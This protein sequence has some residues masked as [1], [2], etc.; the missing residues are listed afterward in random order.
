MP[1][2]I[3]LVGAVFLITGLRGTWRQ[4]GSLLAQD[5]TGPNNFGIWLFAFFLVGSVGY[6][7]GW[8]RFSDA[9]LL[10]IVISI[11]IANDQNG[12]GFFTN[13]QGVMSG[14]AVGQN[15]LPSGFSSGSGSGM[16][17][18]GGGGAGW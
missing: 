6:I 18:S 4:L 9:F 14:N 3:L 2:I 10:L 1:F 8:K 17:Y 12:S 16:G 7:P 5:F 13:L 11:L 15:Q